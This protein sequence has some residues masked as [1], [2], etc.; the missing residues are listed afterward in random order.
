MILP[1]TL[2]VD[3][4]WKAISLKTPA[5]GDFEWNGDI[6]PITAKR[7]NLRFADHPRTDYDQVTV[8]SMLAIVVRPVSAIKRGDSRDCAPRNEYPLASDCHSSLL[9]LRL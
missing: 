3:N 9:R 1:Q 5:T 7:L 8:R 6:T 2:G 4:R